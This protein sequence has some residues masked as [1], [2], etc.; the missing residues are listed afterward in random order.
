MV[1]AFEVASTLD[2]SQFSRL[3]WQRKL[4]HHITEHG[5]HQ[6]VLVAQP[7]QAPLARELFRQ[8][9]S[10]EVKPAEQDSSDLGGYIKT[11]ALKYSVIR[12][13]SQ[14][15]LTLILIV[16]CCVLWL[17][18]P[19]E[20]P[21]PWTY[22]LRF[23][24]FSLGTGT[25]V[26]SRVLDSFGVLEFAKML[27]PI[28]LHGGLLHLAFNM[29]WLWE[30]GRRIEWVQRWLS[31]A[32]TIIVIALFSNT[33]QYFE[34]GHTNFGGMSGV[35][36]GLFGYIW[37]WQLF[38]PRKGLSLPRSLIIY[39]LVMLALFTYLDLDMIANAAHMG[40]LLTGIVYGALVATISRVRRAV[41]TQAKP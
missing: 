19:L 34:G 20:R 22:A 35:I 4:S 39:M 2:L 29:M 30:L 7:D 25:I 31:F 32:G 26:L 3:L 36:Y 15:P 38:D 9:Q 23:P 28:L 16:V 17:L 37:M 13:L 12:N 40:G 5:Q 10:G 1:P 24:D 27:T 6:L 21:T 11:D 18:A 33:I 8:W 14:S 41:T